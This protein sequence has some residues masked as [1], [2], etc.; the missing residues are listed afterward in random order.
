MDTSLPTNSKRCVLCRASAGLILGALSWFADQQIVASRAFAKCTPEIERFA[1]SVA[2][3]CGAVALLGWF[4]SWRIYQIKRA[5]QH[6]LSDPITF[7]ALLSQLMVA[8]ALLGIIFS[9]C[10]TL[11][12][13]CER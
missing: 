12:L 8:I 6:A 3:V 13:Q 7:I 9:T 11:I 5:E 10:A 4:S 2:V 1:I